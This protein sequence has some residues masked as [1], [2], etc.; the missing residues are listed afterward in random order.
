VTTDTSK[1]E[2]MRDAIFKSV[3]D[4]MR[5]GFIEH[6][7]EAYLAIW[8]DDAVLIGGRGPD[9]SASDLRLEREQFEAIKRL[10]FAPP[11]SPVEITVPEHEVSISGEEAVLRWRMRFAAEGFVEE[12]QEVYKLRKTSEGWR[13][14]ENRYWTLTSGDPK[15]PTQTDAAYW[16]TQDQSVLKATESGTASEQINAL[17]QAMRWNEAHALLTEVTTKNPQVAADWAYRG[18]VALQ[19]GLIADATQS[20]CQARRLAPDE[21]FAD[22]AMLLAC[23]AP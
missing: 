1:D 10:R 7:V 2:E 16:E 22:W 12:A 8:T 23:P 11:A 9:A 21:T 18:S 3:G 20:S 4:A 17:T 14:Y 15:T 6:D 13:V 19:L 5:A